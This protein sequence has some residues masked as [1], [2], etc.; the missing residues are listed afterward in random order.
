MAERFEML[1]EN[2]GVDR[3]IKET[4]KIEHNRAN[5]CLNNKSYRINRSSSILM[6]AFS[7][8]HINKRTEQFRV[9]PE[10]L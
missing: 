10:H 1:K 9:R 5:S 7:D 3:A 4:D 2:S 8:Q 6:D